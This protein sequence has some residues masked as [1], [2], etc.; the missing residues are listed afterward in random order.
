MF[1]SERSGQQDAKNLYENL[2]KRLKHFAMSPKSTEVLN[3]ALS[4]MEMNDIHLLNW[5]SSLG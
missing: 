4:A 2:Q 3:K 5:G 1:T